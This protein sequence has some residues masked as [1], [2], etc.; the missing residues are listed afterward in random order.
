MTRYCEVEGCKE[1]S[2]YNYRNL[3]PSRC[4]EH[5]LVGMVWMVSRQCEC[6]KWHATYGMPDDRWATVC[7]N[8][9]S[10]EMEN[11]KDKRICENCKKVRA[12][13]GL[14]GSTRATHCKVCASPEMEDVRNKK[15][16]KCG[17]VRPS[18]GLPGCSLATHCKA[19]AS[20]D[21]V[22]VITPFCASKDCDTRGK[23]K[24]ED[25][26]KRY[27]LHCILTEH[28]LGDVVKRMRNCVRKEIYILAELERRLPWLPTVAEKIQWD[29]GVNGTC[30]GN[31]PDLLL[32]FGSYVL[33]IEVDERQHGSYCVSGEKK[34]MQELWEELGC[35][36]M[37]HIRFNPDTYT[38]SSGVKHKGI[39][40]KYKATN[41][42]PRLRAAEDGEF[43][44]RIDV[45]QAVVERMIEGKIEG[46][47]FL[48]YTPEKE[49]DPDSPD[50]DLPESLAG[51]TV[52]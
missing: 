42:E 48:F 4:L 27:C 47:E 15:C 23:Y 34:R 37:G 51:L 22:D 16:N 21:M 45:L 25:D 2:Q 5:L 29:V 50:D 41:Q 28:A 7:K 31:R 3:R 17:K 13:F 11:I 52:S 9:K 46:K 36:P 33:I 6:G 14:P 35:P 26:G 19:C 49:Y 20:I 24:A 40:T 32:H 38:D 39:F 44:P 12:N 43:V 18:F 30:S 1:P 10:Q 8:C